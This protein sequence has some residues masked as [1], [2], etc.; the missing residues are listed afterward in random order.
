VSTLELS[1][2]IQVLIAP[3]EEEVR[4]T[5]LRIAS[6]PPSHRG[7]PRTELVEALRGPSPPRLADAVDDWLVGTPDDVIARI[8]VY[9]DLGISHFMLWFI[10]YPSMSGPR[11]F[12]ER[13]L[14]ALQGAF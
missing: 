10:D 12:A 2:E 6:L 4:E 1:L 14:P 7:T 3:T 8:K 11:L 9:Q 5:A 13:V